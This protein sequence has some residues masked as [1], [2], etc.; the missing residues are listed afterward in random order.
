[1]I[2]DPIESPSRLPL[3]DFFLR[4]WGSGGSNVP[5]VVRLR[6]F[7][8][9]FGEMRSSTFR[10]KTDVK[11]SSYTKDILAERVLGV[12]KGFDGVKFLD[13]KQKNVEICRGRDFKPGR[14]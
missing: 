5:R 8:K 12:W 13:A 4:V 14:V 3:V 10:S 9:S 1:M 11:S 2:L 7:E 6:L